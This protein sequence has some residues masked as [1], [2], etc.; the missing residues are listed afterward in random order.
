MANFS[1]V[2]ELSGK[3]VSVDGVPGISCNPLLLF[4]VL[5]ILFPEFEEDSV[6]EKSHFHIKESMKATQVLLLFL[7]KISNLLFF[8]INGFQEF[9]D[10][11]LLFIQINLV[12]VLIILAISFLQHFVLFHQIVV[13]FREDS[14]VG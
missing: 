1:P 9:I 12:I 8:V 5:N 14:V 4:L 7:P 3:F 10:V 2:S 13:E 6:V 11:G